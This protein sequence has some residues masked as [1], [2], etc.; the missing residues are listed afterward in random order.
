MYSSSSISNKFRWAFPIASGEPTA[1]FH[2][3]EKIRSRLSAL[4]GIELGAIK[5]ELSKVYLNLLTVGNEC[6]ELVAVETAPLEES[7]RT[8]M[9]ENVTLPQS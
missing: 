3:G 1:D 5:V 7:H 4:G 8:L 9:D 2:Q 6:R